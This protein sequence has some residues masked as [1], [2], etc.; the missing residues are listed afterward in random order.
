MGLFDDALKNAVPGGD[1]TKPLVI[2][3]GALILGKML[4]GHSQSAQ[5]APAPTSVPTSAPAPAPADD[6]G[7]LGGLGGLLGKLTQAGHGEIAN[8]W[9]GHGDNAPISPGQLGG[10]LGQT[11]VTDLARQ[12]GV[13][14]DELLQQLSKVLPNLVHNLTPNGRLPTTADVFDA[15]R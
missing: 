5:P 8:S 4:S 14:E 13:S 9:V 10:A 1:L 6:G 3:A 2:A 15:P 11:T 12:A 7:L